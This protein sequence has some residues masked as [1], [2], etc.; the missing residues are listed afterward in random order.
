[1]AAATA[2][3]KPFDGGFTFQA[4]LPRALV[5]V[6]TQLKEPFVAVGVDVVIHRGSA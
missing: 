1:M 2:N 4:R 5:D 3:H 6:V